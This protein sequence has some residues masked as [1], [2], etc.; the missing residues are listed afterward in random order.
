M[1]LPFSLDVIQKSSDK[2][3]SLQSE[4]SDALGEGVNDS[5]NTVNSNIS[6][7]ISLM[8]DARS[9]GDPLAMKELGAQ[10]TKEIENKTDIEIDIEYETIADMFRGYQQLTTPQNIVSLTVMYYLILQYILDFYYTKTTTGSQS[11]SDS[12]AAQTAALAALANRFGLIIDSLTGNVKGVGK[13]A[14]QSQI[15]TLNS[16]IQNFSQSSNAA[17]NFVNKVQ[18]LCTHQCSTLNSLLTTNTSARVGYVTGIVQTL[19]KSV[20]NQLASIDA[21]KTMHVYVNDQVNDHTTVY[22]RLQSLNATQKRKSAFHVDDLKALNRWSYWCRVVFWV[23]V[24]FFVLMVL[25][26]QYR[27]VASFTANM[28]NRL[29]QVASAARQ[30]VGAAGQ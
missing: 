12:C 27:A 5:L 7:T 22:Q 26:D 19:E 16:S 11:S 29:K 3:S 2:L 6:G 28:D 4:F 13:D 15:T 24:V 9:L 17:Q 14:V 21:L 23:L 20:E 30:V 18:V 1:S 10:L 8:D 25:V